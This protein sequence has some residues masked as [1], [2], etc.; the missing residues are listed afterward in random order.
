MYYIFKL[1]LYKAW[2]MWFATRQCS[3]IFAQSYYTKNNLTIVAI[4]M[5]II[6]VT[7]TPKEQHFSCFI[8]MINVYQIRPCYYQKFKNDKGT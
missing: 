1:F 6:R 7:S 3:V 5:E 4:K 2:K 8:L